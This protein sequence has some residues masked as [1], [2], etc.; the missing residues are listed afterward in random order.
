MSIQ[1]APIASLI[2]DLLALTFADTLLG[3]IYAPLQHNVSVEEGLTEFSTAGNDIIFGTVGND[4]LTSPGGGN[5]MIVGNGGTDTMV[6]S[7][8]SSDYLVLTNVDGSKTVTDRRAGSPDG[9]DTLIGIANLAFAAGISS[10]VTSG[11]GITNGTGDVGDGSIVTL[12]VNFSEVVTVAGGTPT[13]T[14][15]DGGV[16]SYS[17]GSGT[18]ALIFSYV[19]TSGQ[20]TADLAISSFNLPTGVTVQNGAGTSVV[21]TTATDYNPTGVLKIDTTAPAETVNIIAMTSDSGVSGD[22]I[23]NIGLAGRTVSGTVSASLPADEVVQVSFD[24]GANWV[25]ATV[26]GTAW[27]VTDSSSHAA[28]WTIQARVRDLAGN[29]GATVS[30]SVTLDTTTPVA[31]STPDL[32]AASD[33]GVSS[34][35]KSPR[36]PPRPSPAQ[37]RP[38]AR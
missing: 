6:Y 1:G 28:N 3:P 27:S 26:A 8:A 35:D 31:P 4:R 29:L 23:T 30:R 13:L 18:S 12:T 36:P 10:I 22:F 14:L 24:N 25:A 34:T 19:V 9:T 16:A 2:G 33:S 32:V 17:G 5:D 37:P 21:L 38:A 11:T 15:N 7:G 20:N